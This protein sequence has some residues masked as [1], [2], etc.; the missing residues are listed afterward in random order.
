MT[1]TSTR[2]TT[3]RVLP[4]GPLDAKMVFFG[5]APGKDEDDLG[6]LFV[7]AAGQFLDRGFRQVGIIRSEVLIANLFDQ[8]P[9]NNDAKYFFQDKSCTK[10]TWEG[11]E[12]LAARREWL[13][14]LRPNVVVALGRHAMYLLT[15]K[16]KINK[17]R[18][19]VLPCTLVEGLKVYPMFHPS[20]IQRMLSEPRDRI[21][22]ERK[23]DKQNLLP[24]FQIDLKRAK[25][26]SEFPE[27]RYPQRNFEI[28][29]NAFEAIARIQALGPLAAVDIET[30]QSES[31]PF[32]WF[33]GFS[34]S[35]E[36]AFTVPFL[37]NFRFAR[38]AE[39]DAELLVEVSKF[40]LDPTKQKI[41]QGGQYDLA[42]LGRYYGLRVAKG[43]YQD[44]MH[45]HHATYP[46]M[47]KALH[48]LSSIYT[49]EPYY[50]D[51]GKVGSGRRTTD[52]AEGIYNCKDC[53]VTRECLPI[54]ERN[55]RI[56]GT[57]S[58]YERTL[59]Y[60]PA[61]LSMELRGIRCDI[62]RKNQLQVEFAGR[63]SE[64]QVRLNELADNEYN[65]NSTDAMRKLLYGYLG[66]ELQLHTKT[67]KPTTDKAALQRLKKLNP[68]EPILDCILDFRK[69]D[70]L[71]STYAEMKVDSDG[72]LHT[73]FGFTSTWR[74]T[75]SESPFGSG[76]NLQNIP[77]RTEEGR[78][79]RKV[80]VA[81]E[82]L[83]LLAADYAKAEDM[84]VTWE[85]DNLP[86]IEKYKGEHDV[87]WDM[88]KK[89]FGIPDT[90]EYKKEIARKATFTDYITSEPHTLH[91]LRDLGKRVR[92]A[93]NYGMGPFVFQSQLEAEGFFLPFA[94]CKAML[95][96]AAYADPA[97]P[98]WQRGVEAKIR[99]NRCLIT[100][101]GRKREFLG[102]LGSELYK[103]AYAFS[104]QSTVGELMCITMSRIEAKLDYAQLLHNIHDEVIVQVKPSDLA[105]AQADIQ[106]LGSIPL[107]IH[108]RELIIPLD[109]KTGLSWGELKEI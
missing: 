42:V 43:S 48:V 41:F 19:S 16:D 102:R 77:V 40:F 38:S 72:R 54:E 37:Q 45:L 84:V 26:Q 8:R 15:G 46:Y 60:M 89:V 61:I 83:V 66:L 28:V 47:R 92:H 9:P 44:T 59:T 86:K 53:A 88:A 17:W 12:H 64:A 11:E 65:I 99:E 109:F 21:G 71:C 25:E 91:E 73:Q 69:F 57:F 106:E 18:G 35:P 94:V 14:K 98:N 78:E 105:K 70:K 23:L 101:L 82:G 75:S 32:L 7:G 50:K 95:E 49:W 81:D 6:R 39:E 97:V 104:P 13:S 87:H 67:K 1:T 80:F 100:P 24:L 55:A 107:E 58:G 4:E 30:L 3:R 36:R 2:L 27:I 5:E 74:L 33:I 85:A 22:M 96:Q 108:G 31:G 93:S 29:W 20:H 79:L 51:E 103:S 34:D 68:K 52:E 56:L 63:A 90:V 76:G 62:E 10:L